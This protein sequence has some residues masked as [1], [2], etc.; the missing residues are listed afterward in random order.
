MDNGLRLID[1]IFLAAIIVE[2]IAI[3]W[4]ARYGDQSREEFRR[5]WLR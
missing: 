4:L 5:R 2:G 3:Y 1:L